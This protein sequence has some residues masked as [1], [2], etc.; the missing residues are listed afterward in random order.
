M[1]VPGAPV[2]SSGMV[3]PST[4]NQIVVALDVNTM[5]TI[6]V[7]CMK[8][9]VSPSEVTV[10]Y[11]NGTGLLYQTPKEVTARKYRPFCT[12]APLDCYEVH[13]QQLISSHCIVFWRNYVDY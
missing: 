3:P 11:F 12:Y 4:L 9:G 10:T 1:Q 8:T 13:S 7:T 5:L 6:E 2:D